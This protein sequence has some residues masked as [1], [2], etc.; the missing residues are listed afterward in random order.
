MLR[1][2]SYCAIGEWD[3]MDALVS[4]RPRM[5]PCLERFRAMLE[6]LGPGLGVTDPVFGKIILDSADLIPI[7]PVGTGADKPQAA[8]TM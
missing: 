6:K 1:E 5:I 8:R 7:P 2:R 3:S 4:A